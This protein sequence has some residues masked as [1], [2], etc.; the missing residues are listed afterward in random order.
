MN[1]ARARNRWFCGLVLV[2]VLLVFPATSAGANDSPGKAEI[3]PD[4]V[5]IPL[6]FISP[7]VLEIPAGLDGWLVH[8]EEEEI[9]YLSI[10]AVTD[11][12]V[13]AA[14]RENL[15]DAAS[16]FILYTIRIVELGTT[17]TWG[18]VF[19]GEVGS[20]PAAEGYSIV[21]TPQTLQGEDGIR[22]LVE[23]GFLP[24]PGA[25]ESRSYRGATEAWIIAIP[26]RPVTWR[27]GTIYPED[28]YK[29]KD[30]NYLLE[31]T[32]AFINRETGRVETNVSFLRENHGHGEKA[33]LATT[34][35][36]N[37]GK[38]E[39]VA[40][41]RR[42]VDRE[43]K[44]LLTA[45]L[46]DQ[47]V[48]ALVLSA[49]P[50]GLKQPEE[51]P[52]IP[53]ASLDGLKLLASD[54]R[55]APAPEREMSIE[56]G[57][58]SRVSGSG[59]EVN[60]AVRL[61][62]L[63]NGL[64][65][66]EVSAEAPATYFVAVK[67]EFWAGAGTSLEAALAGGFGT[68][69]RPTLM[70]GVSD[71]VQLSPDLSAFITWYPLVYMMDGRSGLEKSHWRAGLAWE[72][73]NLELALAFIGSPQWSSQRLEAVLPI[74]SNLWLRLGIMAENWD[75]PGVFLALGIKQKSE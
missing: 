18:W 71:K 25:P 28:Y 14:L 58:I 37:G 65:G 27:T 39:I 49:L 17:A 60:P 48:F 33:A 74:E 46:K 41:M 59:E 10:P 15:A 61:A 40:L 20:G 44:G 55:P 26:G 36:S 57:L 75:S 31:I 7:G 4:L 16:L 54:S 53:M 22:F 66:L 23:N 62:V 5:F 6:G 30:E 34:V 35:N 21:A 38:P 63:L 68:L 69:T 67:R 32:P 24:S 64:T 2:L 73:E 1:N 3:T 51:M 52:V 50:F 19:T 29:T 72:L 56:A 47:R 9:Y 13:L 42:T 70:A 45:G 8:D 11:E 12:E 43:E